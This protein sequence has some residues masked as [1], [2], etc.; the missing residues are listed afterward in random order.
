MIYYLYSN[1]VLN[2]LHNQQL[3]MIHHYYNILNLVLNFHFFH[4]LLLL[5]H[6][7]IIHQMILVQLYPIN[8]LYYQDHMMQLTINI[9][10][11]YISF[12]WMPC[13]TCYITNMSS[14]IF[15]ISNICITSN[16]CYYTSTISIKYTRST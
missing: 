3:L 5:Q 16:K 12:T 1:I 15:L 9:N 7:I 8:E 10:I 6:Y 11:I 4:F 13:N 14:C 2:H